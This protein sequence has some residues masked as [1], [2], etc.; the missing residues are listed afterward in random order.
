MDNTKRKG[1][2]GENITVHIL[3]KY[4]FTIINRNYHVQQGEIDVIAQKSST[5][6]F[7]EVKTTYGE[8][9]PA[10]NFHRTKL[11]RFLKA[12]RAYCYRH[13]ISE[14]NIEIDLAL[15]NMKNRRFKLI[16]HANIYFH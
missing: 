9:N 8:Y 10:E 4:G 6:H 16:R 12:V 3:Q 14:E 7:I 11:R 5:I 1:D 15:V 2:E 13:S